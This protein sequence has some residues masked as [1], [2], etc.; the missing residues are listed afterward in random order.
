MPKI[1]ARASEGQ[2]SDLLGGTAGLA[3]SL[4]TDESSKGR[5]GEHDARCFSDSRYGAF[6]FWIFSHHFHE[7]QPAAVERL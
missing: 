7:T 2:S 5:E 3:D 1:K 6:L 4:T